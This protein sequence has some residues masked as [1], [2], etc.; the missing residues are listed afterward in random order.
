MPLSLSPLVKKPSSDKKISS[1]LLTLLTFQLSTLVKNT[2]P[3]PGTSS[4][5]TTLAVE[6]PTPPLATVT[7]LT[8][9]FSILEISLAPIPVPLT[10]KSGVAVYPSPERVI[11]TSCIFPSWV[12]IALYSE[13]EPEETCTDGGIAK[14]NIL[15]EPYPKP[16]FSKLIEVIEPLIIGLITAW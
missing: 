13:E 15:C 6:Y 2:A 10:I 1:C 3:V 4:S 5:T 8:L 12:T 14:L 16:G 7:W 9:P 11:I